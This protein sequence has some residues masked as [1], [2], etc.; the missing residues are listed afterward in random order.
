M[1]AQLWEKND[2]NKMN[3]ENPP[4]ELFT[5]WQENVHFEI[6]R[7]C[8]DYSQRFTCTFWDTPTLRSYIVRAPML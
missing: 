6:H 2:Q 5:T 4:N 8:N 7:R 1:G 3:K